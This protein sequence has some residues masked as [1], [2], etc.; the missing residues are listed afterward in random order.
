VQV[1]KGKKEKKEI[2]V[3]ILEQNFIVHIQVNFAFFFLT[4][5]KPHKNTKE[6]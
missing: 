4:R 6:V 2:F 5:E 3:R 1:P